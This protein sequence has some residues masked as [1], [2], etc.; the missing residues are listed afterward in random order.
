LLLVQLIQ[1]D[2][3]FHPFSQ[4]VLACLPDADW[5]LTDDELK[6]RLDLR[7][8]NICSIDPPGTL[9]LSFLSPLMRK[10]LANLQLSHRLYG[11][12]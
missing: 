5:K 11:Y 9:S 1:Y 3:P 12:R 10:P 8:I 6:K 7:E 2:V 4:N